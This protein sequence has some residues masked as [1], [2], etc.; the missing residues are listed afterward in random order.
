MTAPIPPQFGPNSTGAP[1]APRPRGRGLLIAGVV[2]MVLSVIG[3]VVSIGVIASIED[4]LDFE[5][6]VW[7]GPSD[8][9]VPG[10]IEFSV[11]EPIDEGDDGDMTVG[12]AL[13]AVP[14]PEPTCRILDADDTE[15][16]IG[17]PSPQDELLD[18]DG[19][20]FDYQ[21]LRTARVGPGD[22]RASCEVEGEPSAASG[23]SFTVGRVIAVD[24]FTDDVTPILGGFG[25]LML[26]GLLFIV[27]LVLAIVGLVLRSRGSRPPTTGGPYAGVPQPQG[28]Y[29]GA[30]T[31]YGA[32][33]PGYGQPAPPGYGAPP[34]GYGQP[35]PPGYGAP[36]PGYGQPAP[37]GYGQP[38]PPPYGQPTQPAA[39][40]VAE[41]PPPEDGSVGGWTIPPSKQ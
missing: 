24:D 28:P 3:G 18:W 16:A 13:S 36:P 29:Y 22:Y 27:G 19:Y 4:L 12:I 41:P 9:L 25:G 38:T 40:P 5:E 11:L 8:R 33:P 39:P 6:V 1:D 20:Y 37:P 7:D 14:T 21:L 30:P 23:V 32:P 31:P 34:P 15:V 26:S 2:V 10:A 17:P 35:A